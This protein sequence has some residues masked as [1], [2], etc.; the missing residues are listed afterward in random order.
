MLNSN[1]P[2]KVA[3][4]QKFANQ[5]MWNE[6]L[7]IEMVNNSFCESKSLEKAWNVLIERKESHW[8]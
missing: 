2:I 5:T 1:E 6:A 8:L 4:F 7:A 3:H